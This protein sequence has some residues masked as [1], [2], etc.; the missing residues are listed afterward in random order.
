MAKVFSTRVD[1][2]ASAERVWK[3]LADLEGYSAW[4]PFTPRIETTFVVGDPIVLH[5]SFDGAK[6]RRQVEIL[7]SWA[8][9]EQLCWGMTIGPA[10]LFRAERVQRVEVLG[11]QRCRYVSEDAFAGALSPV[12]ELLYGGKVQRGFDA[13]GAALKRRAESGAAQ[14]TIAR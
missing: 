9:G 4:N 7:R 10:W 11:D 5:V 2:A 3:I 1:I 6:P 8:P 13:L 12:V 14:R